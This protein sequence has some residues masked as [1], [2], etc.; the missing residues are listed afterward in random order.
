MQLTMSPVFVISNINFILAMSCF[1]TRFWCCAL[2]AMRA[3]QTGC[4][5][6]LNPFLHSQEPRAYTDS[7]FKQYWMPDSQCK[8]CYECGEKFTT[9]RRRHHCRICGQIFCSRCCN[10]EVPGKFMGFIGNLRVCTYCCKIVLSYAQSVDSTG[11]FKALQE[12]L[13]RVTEDTSSSTPGEGVTPRKK[14]IFREEDMRGRPRYALQFVLGSSVWTV[15]PVNNIAG[16]EVHSFLR[17][18][19]WNLSRTCCGNL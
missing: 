12:D 5:T 6:R 15:T 14:T 16:V 4:V 8:E 13:Q 17:E 11:D 19:T 10:Q 7:D 18:S 9:F 1:M 2:R 3:V